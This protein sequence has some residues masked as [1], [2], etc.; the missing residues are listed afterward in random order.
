[1]RV[2]HIHTRADERNVFKAKAQ[3]SPHDGACISGI[4][5]MVQH[6]MRSVC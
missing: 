3:G 4:G 6:D 1:M 5:G 2:K